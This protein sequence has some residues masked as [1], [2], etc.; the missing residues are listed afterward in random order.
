MDRQPHEHQGEHF[1]AAIARH[2]LALQ[3]ELKRSTSLPSAMF[4]ASDP[5]LEARLCEATE[6]IF[7]QLLEQ[8]A[9]PESDE[10]GEVRLEAVAAEEL[11]DLVRAARRG[12]FADEALPSL[13]E[14]HGEEFQALLAETCA[15]SH[16]AA[17]HRAAQMLRGE[18]ALGPADLETLTRDLAAR[19][20]ALDTGKD[21]AHAERMRE[22]CRRLAATV[23]RCTDEATGGK[24]A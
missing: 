16:G 12:A 23:L 11:Q 19:L 24:D 10:G 8:D 1:S 22:V 20:L 4:D 13:T 21:A 5:M 15:R 7:R 9:P 14:F 6:G 17:Q 18:H 2:Q 3:T